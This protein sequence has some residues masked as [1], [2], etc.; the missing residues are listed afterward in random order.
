PRAVLVLQSRPAG[1]ARPRRHTRAAVPRLARRQALGRLLAPP[2]V[3]T[4]NGGTH[5]T[6]FIQPCVSSMC[7]RW[8]ANSVSRSRAATGPVWPPLMLHSPLADLTAPTGV[9][10]SAVPLANTYVLLPFPK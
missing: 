2:R 3:P 8:M 7:P 9:I 1:R 4:N 6:R 10:T 5:V